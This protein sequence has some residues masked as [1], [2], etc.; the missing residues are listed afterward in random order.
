MAQISI[1][2]G[3]HLGKVAPVERYRLIFL[4]A[5]FMNTLWSIPASSQNAARNDASTYDCL[6]EPHQR[7][8]VATPVPGV[9]K[10]VFVDRGMY[11]Q[12]G[13]LIAQL[14][15]GVEEAALALSEERAGNDATLK[16]RQARLEFLARKRDRLSELH[17]K[18]ATSLAALDEAQ[19]DLRLATHDV[20]EAESS[21]ELARLEAKRAREV[22]RQRSIFSPLA[23]VVIERNLWRG[24]YAYEQAPILSL[25]QVDP[26]NIEVYLPTAIY[27]MVKM[28]MKADIT[29]E[30]P[31]EGRYKADVVVID[32]IFDSRSG[33]FGIR[34]ELANPGNKLPAGLRCKVVF[35]FERASR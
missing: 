1:C 17:A 9:L 6:M 21:I 24:E 26:L 16:G 20:R 34:L 23:G 32:S 29:P 3:T 25:A 15:S 27:G 11:V 19:T 8:K 5:F 33:T 22:L 14:Q 35:P 2:P 18:G 7:V 31:T 10:D 30:S 13:Q 4:I 12:K 28:G